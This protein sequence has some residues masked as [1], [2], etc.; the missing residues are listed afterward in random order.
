MSSEP[1]VSVPPAPEVTTPPVP[2][3][4]MTAGAS[5]APPGYE[6]LGELGRGGMGVVYRARQVALDR[7]CALK[8]ILAGGH[9]GEDERGRFLAEAEA[10]AKVRH[11]GIVQVFDFGT[12]EGLPFFSLEL[13]EGGSLAEKLREHPLPPREATQVLE[14]IAR[15]V[16]AAHAAGIVHRDLKPG[17]VLLTQDGS[18]RVTDFGL[19][20]RLES[21]GQTQTGAVMGTPS[22]MAPEQAQG[23]KDLGPAADVWALG[24]M[25]YACVTGRPPFQ[26]ATSLDTILQVIRDEPVPVRQL[27]PQVPVDLETIAHKC[28]QKDPAKRYA[29]A[30]ALADDL[31]R[32][33]RGEPITARPVGAVERGVK[34]V[35]RHKTVS[36][37]GAAVVLVLLAGVT[38]ALLLT[39]WALKEARNAREAEEYAEDQA[40]EAQSRA[41]GEA[42]A[43][44]EA[45]EEKRRAQE[46]RDRA[47]WSAYAG[48]LLL[49][50]GAFAEKNMLRGID[51][52]DEC[53]W[54]LRGW[55]HAYLRWRADGSRQ[56]LTG[57]GPGARCAAFSPDGR[58]IVT[59]YQDGT[60]MIWDSEEGQALSKLSAHDRPITC[61]AWSPD[62]QRIVTGSY[63]P[64]VKVWE[65]S[66][67]KELV[68]LSGHTQGV[69]SVAFSRDGRRV[70]TM[71][72]QELVQVWD[73]QTGA[74]L[75]GLPRS[76]YPM[77]Q[78]ALQADGE[79]AV[80]VHRV[81]TRGQVWDV[82]RGIAVG[83][84]LGLPEVVNCVAISPEGR[85]MVSGSGGWG[86]AGVGVV[87]DL[88]T[89]REL[90]QLRGHTDQVTGV[91]FSPDGKQVLTGSRDGTGRVWDVKTGQELLTLQGH[92]GALIGV[93]FGADGRRMLT[94]SADG[95]VKVWDSEQRRGELVLARNQGSPSSA[96]FS[97]D[98]TRLVTSSG[99]QMDWTAKVWDART[100]VELLVLRG[101]TRMVNSVAFRPDGQRIVTGSG[102]DTTRPGE[103]KIWDAQ[104]GKELRALHGQSRRVNSVAYSPDGRRI[105]GASQDQSLRVWDAETGKV[106]WTRDGLAGPIYSVTYT[107]D[108]RRIVG[109]NYDF[110][111]TVWD[112]EQG[113]EMVHLRGHTQAVTRVAVSPDGRRI[114]TGVTGLEKTARVWDSTTGRELLVLQGHAGAVRD[115]AF[116][117]DGKRCL[118]AST[119][120]TVKVW[121]A[122]YG[123]DLLTLREASG[124]VTSLAMSPDG[125]QLFTASG[126]DLAG[127]QRIRTVEKVVGGFVLK[128]HL[129]LVA[130]VAFR[131]DGQRILTGSGDR[132]ARVWDA[133]TGKTLQ[134]L[135]GHET[136]VWCVAYSPDGTRILTGSHD[137]TAR[138]WDATTGA[139]LFVWPGHEQ[140]VK[141]VA[142]SADGKV[143]YTWDGKENVRGWECST[144]NPVSVE[145]PVPVPV[146]EPVLSPDGRYRAQ[147]K[148]ND[149]I[150]VEVEGKGEMTRWPVPGWTERLRYHG[151]QAA[152]AEREQQ[153]FAAEFHRRRMLRDDPLNPA[154]HV[155][156]AYLALEC[157]QREQAVSQWMQA[158]LLNPRG[159]LYVA[160]PLA[161]QRGQEA[162]MRDDWEGAQIAFRRALT[163]PGAP[164]QAWVNLLLAQVAADR[165][166]KVRQSIREIAALVPT[167][168]E[169]ARTELL[170]HALNYRCDVTT[171][172]QLEAITGADLQKA[173]NAETLHRHGLALLWA[174]KTEAARQHLADSM[175]AHGKGG[176]PTTW[177]FLSLALRDL[178]QIEE[179]SRLLTQATQWHTKQRF[180]TW[181]ARVIWMGLLREANL[182]PKMQRIEAK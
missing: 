66:S 92:R 111:A 71:S 136:I 52:L 117:P 74:R 182:A 137:R 21:A 144:G 123:N 176:F 34:W 156:L 75:Q 20:K 28:L 165:P 169:P 3:E 160:D 146:A 170:A 154:H 177:V 107:P 14:A 180:P 12:H 103:V 162:A 51:Y 32:Y 112:A 108:G 119:D 116:S 17:N 55:E 167:L 97:R 42:R 67:G 57:H 89:G 95:T 58:R 114:L 77:Y 18:P 24:A 101:H 26:A 159:A 22:Y 81:P 131:P 96:A 33:L 142:F 118:T 19:A 36:A 110:T 102:D 152:Q 27:N 155:N 46:E 161:A 94:A 138:L 31:G 129:S 5:V 83:A 54:H 80:V 47:E 30:Q 171:A 86:E 48:K 79:R 82:A 87:W 100:G 16:Q 70:L 173:R 125:Q 147:K 132:T 35:R 62:G 59:G 9:A 68:R 135:R 91:V 49:A 53:P 61:V 121:D 140:Q 76:K 168:R 15:A 25:L 39:D 2:A 143:A 133:Q 60:V 179:S 178:G 38:V 105:V 23:K 72:R 172:G 151:E 43:N 65:V 98:G 149:V 141:R 84:E 126:K 41:E 85:Q 40:E 99:H 93:A 148:G 10:I 29:T 130:S 164:P 90:V 45:Q 145:G 127:V 8:M 174:G 6:I 113:K 44:Q 163:Q 13:C 124:V 134:T 88:E 63:N 150:L 115:V 158:L 64:S 1:T 11:P 106:V 139:E 128:G 104:T 78:V 69:E 157:Q 122:E 175:A 7:P 181:Q 120:G 73:A 50:Q 109:G 166:D 4:G 37:L 56:T 153:W